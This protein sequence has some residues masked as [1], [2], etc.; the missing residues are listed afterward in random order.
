MYVGWLL[1]YAV[2]LRGITDGRSWVFLALFCTFGSDTAAY[3][4]GRAIGKH[5]LAPSISP[6][7]T[8]EGAAGGLLGAMG[9]ALLFLLPTPVSLASYLTWWQAVIIGS[10][11]SVFGQLGD[12]VESLFKRNV[13]AKDSG[14]LLAGHG[15]VL[16]RTDSVMFA[17]VVVYYWVICITP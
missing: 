1:G 12:L 17:V 2:A 3:F 14:T 4:L 15:G 5:K 10:I 9:V 8:W 11:V 6:G 16:D 7:K 13:G